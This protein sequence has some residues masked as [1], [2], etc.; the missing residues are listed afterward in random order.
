MLATQTES[1]TSITIITSE[2]LYKQMIQSALHF[3]HHK[4][5]PT[6][7]WIPKNS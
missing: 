7:M 2:L 1:D 4:S 3:S 6:Q 5:Y